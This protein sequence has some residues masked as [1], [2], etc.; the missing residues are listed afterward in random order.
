MGCAGGSIS[1]NNLFR[2]STGLFSNTNIFS[3]ESRLTSSEGFI[4]PK[5]GH[6]ED[7][8]IGNQCPSCKI[9]KEQWAQESGEESCE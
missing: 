7:G 8:P 1:I 2:H 9:T 6:H 4:C 5:C 3:S